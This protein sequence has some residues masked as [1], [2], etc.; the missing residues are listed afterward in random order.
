MDTSK[1]Q[2]LNN[3]FIGRKIYHI[4]VICNK[5]YKQILLFIRHRRIYKE[6]KIPL[7]VGDTIKLGKKISAKIDRE[8]YILN[9]GK[10]NISNLKEG[11]HTVELVKNGRE[12]VYYL[13]KLYSMPNVLVSEQ[14]IKY[15]RYCKKKFSQALYKQY[16]QTDYSVSNNSFGFYGQEH[17]SKQ[18]YDEN[19]IPLVLINNE[20]V[21]HPTNLAQYALSL[22]PSKDKITDEEKKRF[23][24]ISNF[25]CNSCIND[26]GGIPFHFSFNLKNLVYFNRTFYSAMTQGQ[27]LSVLSRAYLLTGEEKYKSIANKVFSFMNRNCK[28]DLS[29]FCKH[30]S[31]LKK[32]RN[33]IMFE[34]YVHR[35]DSYV[36]NGSLFAIAGIHDWFEISGLQEVKEAFDKACDTIA[37]LLPYYDFY[38]ISSYDLLHFTC[39]ANADFTCVYAHDYHIAILDALYYWT[40]NEIFSKYRDLFISYYEDSKYLE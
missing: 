28:T 40:K 20:L 30:F 33:N 36:L 9:K 26:D 27:V 23:I 12:K 35:T 34:E 3:Y 13:N 17:F 15:G 18:D 19:G 4:L 29:Q 2:F 11:W 16:M 1:I 10:L 22:F 25:I 32:I 39:G 7:L 5:I 38:G 8:N 21:Y 31:E 24:K 6:K 37:I 14:I